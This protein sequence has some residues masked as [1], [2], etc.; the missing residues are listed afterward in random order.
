MSQTYT[1]PSTL[2]GITRLAK[3]LSR[4]RGIKHT[5]ALEAAAKIAGYEN[6]LH[7]KRQLALAGS[8]TDFQPL[9]LTVYWRD[10]EARAHAGR[11]TASVLMPAENLEM[12]GALKV[13]GYM[14]LGGFELE[15]ADHLQARLD[16]DS[17]AQAK[18]MTA[19]A[20]RELL[21]CVAT[22]LRRARKIADRRRT[23]FIQSLPGKDHTSIWVDPG[24]GSWIAIDEPYNDRVSGS[25][26]GREAWLQTHGLWSAAP[27]WEGLYRPGRTTPYVISPDQELWSRTIKAVEQM[28]N[29]VPIDWETLSGSYHSYFHSPQ[30]I[31]SG[32]AY[33]PRPQPSYAKRSGALPYGGYPGVAS[34]W[35]PAAAMPIAQHKALG[36]ILKGLAWI[37]IPERSIVAI[38]SALSTLDDW[39]NYE[40]RDAPSHELDALYMVGERASLKSPSEQLKAIAAARTLFRNGYNDCR[41]RRVMME[42][43]DTLESEVLKKTAS[44]TITE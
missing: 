6:F 17:E 32:K 23:E 22:G 44:A 31:A 11:C 40:H 20:I 30:R 25:V 26:S 15:S 34:K 19:G 12:L 3:S 14:L 42:L 43:L 5:H 16:A 28:E 38:R 9:Y 7:A 35:R 13:R 24:A 18:D 4:E 8:S 36:I 37:D 10:V 1:P 41:P 27:A 2:P 29:S 39:A 33:R 21:F